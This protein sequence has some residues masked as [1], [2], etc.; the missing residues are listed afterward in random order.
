LVTKIIFDGGRAQSLQYLKKKR[1]YRADRVAKGDQ[2]D[3]EELATD[4]GTVSA[5]REI[6][7]AAGAFNTPQ[8]LML[9]GIG[10]AAHLRQMGVEE[11]IVDRPEVGGN[12]QDRYEIPVIDDVGHEFKLLAPYSF[13]GDAQ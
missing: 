9:S 2:R 7:L 1:A 8:L 13:R 3:L 11:I 6:I 12:L 5:S 10:P 4:L